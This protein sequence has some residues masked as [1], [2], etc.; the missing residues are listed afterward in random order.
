MN[1]AI[2]FAGGVGTRM[3]SDIP[4][5][6]LE[7]DG[8]PVLV[9]TLEIFERHPRVDGIV[10]VVAPGYFNDCHVLAAKYGVTKIRALAACGDSAQDSIYSGLRAAADLFPPETT[11]LLHDGVRPYLEPEV[12][13]ANIDAV[14]KFG[15][16]VT[17]TP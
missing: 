12:I 3:G 8:K 15:S 5:Q 7:L 10:L 17:Y 16:A 13:D 2:V 9:H 1:I 11:V 6:F 14:E 4:K